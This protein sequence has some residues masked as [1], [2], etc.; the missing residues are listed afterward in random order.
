MKSG[1][2]IKVDRV[3]DWRIEYE[4]NE[5][6]YIEVKQPL[7]EF[8]KPKYRLVVGSIDLKQIECIVQH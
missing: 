7:T 6:T 2:S 5:I 3:E 1:N 8:F 4:G